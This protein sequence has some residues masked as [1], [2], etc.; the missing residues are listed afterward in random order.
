MKTTKQ[1]SVIV[2]RAFAKI[3]LGLEVLA[4][5]DDGYHELRTILQTVDFC[6]VLTFELGGDAISLSTSDPVLGTG[7]E[8]LVI[9]AATALAAGA[10]GL[11]AS[12]H[13]EKKIPAGMGLGGGSADA[14]MTLL[15]LDRLW[16]LQ[17]PLPE[18]HRLAASIGTDVPFF[19]YGG[20]AVAVGRGDELYPCP[21]ELDSPIVLILPEFSIST[22]SAYAS[23]RLTKRRSGLT[24]QHF[25]WGGPCV[26]DKLGEMVNHLE[27]TTGSRTSE[28]QEYKKLLLDR[29]A[30]AA[31]M[32]GSGSAVFGVFQ[33][34]HAARSVADSLNRDGIRAVVTRTLDREAYCEKRLS[35]VEE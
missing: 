18:L 27:G 2:A 15:A 25:A 31:M 11:R 4:K 8:N 20:A 17:T 7:P 1:E 30:L 23:L 9:R 5:R 12:I 3:N 28:I 21:V 16:N 14:A 26:R 6:D 33:E 10:A 34:V 29:G 19:L 32:S 35:G 22:A 13:L 24:L